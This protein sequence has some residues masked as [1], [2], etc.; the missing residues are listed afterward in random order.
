MFPGLREEFM[1]KNAISFYFVIFLFAIIQPVL[2]ESSEYIYPTGMSGNSL[3][4]RGDKA[5]LIKS[6]KSN[7]DLVL[8]SFPALVEL[9]RVPV[10]PQV[11]NAI[12]SDTGIAVY[13]YEYEESFVV[14][15]VNKIKKTFQVTKVLTNID[16]FNVDL[17]PV[18]NLNFSDIYETEIPDDD[19]NR[20]Y[21]LGNNPVKKKPKPPCSL[22]KPFLTRSN[23]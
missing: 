18:S 20:V 16:T 22:K 19:S 14:K 6:G 15:T 23:P 7:Y 9:K 10:S 17:E 4:V 13:A 2:A 8:Y 3:V 12:L 5:F 21:P 11:S 1:L